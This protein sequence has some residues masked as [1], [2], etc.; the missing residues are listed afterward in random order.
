M[1]QEMFDVY[2]FPLLTVEFCAALRVALR[3]ISSLAEESD[4]G[5]EFAH[6]LLRGRTVVD[7]DAI[8]LGWITDL[9]FRAYVEPIARHL[10]AV[11]EGMVAT[12]DDLLR[13]DDDAGGG[14]RPVLD[15]RQG[16]VAGYSSHPSRG[17]A[18]TR[19]HLVSH[20]DDSE[21]TLNCCLGDED[22]VGGHVD[23]F[24][25]RGTSDEGT[26]AGTSTRP[27]VGAALLH[28]GRHLHSVADVVSGDRYALI[29]WS[30][31]WGGL[32]A[33]VCPCCWLNR[34]RGSTCICDERWN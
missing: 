1:N 5:E 23:F 26:H 19:R 32:R 25:L 20:T 28:A 24:N 29:V 18:A 22:Y 3:G 2:S 17:R 30:R 13:D 9:L 14:A 7:L 33:R 31:S 6:R 21:V 34:R 11:T 12:E 27:D 4:G 8:G 16:Y 15:W 10:F